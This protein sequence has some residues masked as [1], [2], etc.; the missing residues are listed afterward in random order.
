MS[1]RPACSS[2]RDGTWTVGLFTSGLTWRTVSS[3]SSRRLGD[4]SRGVIRL[5]GCSSLFLLQQRLGV[6]YI[7]LQN[8][9]VRASNDDLVTV[10]VDD[11]MRLWK[12]R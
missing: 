2:R 8:G 6:C 4:C 7:S 11:G 5:R 3:C 12:I 10:A 9:T 1:G